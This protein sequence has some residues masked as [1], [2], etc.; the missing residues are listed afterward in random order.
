MIK[1]LLYLLFCLLT[2][3]Q[4]PVPMENERTIVLIR[5]AK[6]SW[7][8]PDLADFDR[9]L[10]DRG[11]TDAPLMGKQL[12]LQGLR[13]DAIIAS[14]SKRTTQTLSFLLKEIKFPE[15]KIV[16]DS[17][18]FHSSSDNLIHI[19]QSL[20]PSVKTVALVG[21]NPSMT[22]LANYLQSDTLIE[23]VPTCGIVCVRAE[24]PAWSDLQ[25]QKAKLEFFIYPK[26]ISK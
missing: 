8:N 26:G 1:S 17:S 24:L 20:D 3:T 13:F 21:H 9:P 16:W 19:L 11:F 15:S 25:H 12:A 10:N 14:P 6:S 2:Q 23:N 5:H 22:D 7:D 18:I 4:L